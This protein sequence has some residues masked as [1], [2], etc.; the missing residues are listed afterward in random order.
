MGSQAHCNLG[1]RC[2]LL[3][4]FLE[5]KAGLD[6]IIN[7]LNTYNDVFFISGHD[8]SMPDIPYLIVYNKPVCNGI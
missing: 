4:V 8:L 6:L 5:F 7:I 1:I 3:L 2:T